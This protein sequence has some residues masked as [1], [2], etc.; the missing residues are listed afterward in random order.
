MTTGSGKKTSKTGKAPASRGRR[1]KIVDKA[2][3]PAEIDKEKMAAFF[4][5]VGADNSVPDSVKESA[6]VKEDKKTVLKESKVQ[7]LANPTTVSVAENGSTDESELTAKESENDKTI[8]VV[9]STDTIATEKN[10][11]NEKAETVETSIPPATGGGSDSGSYSVLSMVFVLAVLA[12]FWF[13]YIAS[14]P[15]KKA[16]VAQVESGKAEISV[17]M[18]RIGSLEAE[19][20]RLSAQLV[21]FEKA[22]QKPKKIIEKVIVPVESGAVV[23]KE[24]VVKVVAKGSPVPSAVIK[25]DSSFDKAPIPFWR[26]MKRDSLVAQPRK[27]VE[28]A[29]KTPVVKVD[30]FSKAPKPFW[31]KPKVKPEAAKV[32]K[33]MKLSAPPAAK[34]APKSK[35]LTTEQEEPT[36]VPVLDP[37]FQK[38][39]KPFWLKG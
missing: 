6:E 19:V 33:E 9:V 29:V 32:K 34:A 2:P 21:V 26:Q 10:S 23:E 38:A 37:S 5:A 16:V 7:L 24:P 4:S 15:L 11:D 39:P 27:E 30:S 22:A 1:K 3:A 17:L 14:T 8:E 36:P 20:A 13:Y 25:K 31:L 18:S 28:P 12:L 35:K